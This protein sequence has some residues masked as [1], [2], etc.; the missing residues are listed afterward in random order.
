[1]GDPDRSEDVRVIDGTNLVDRRLRRRNPLSR[2]AGVVDQHV[3]PLGVLP[4]DAYSIGNR[5]VG[6]HVQGDHH[7]VRSTADEFVRGC[8]SSTFIT[9]AEKYLPTQFPE[10]A[11]RLKAKSLVASSDQNRGLFRVHDFLQ[12][13]QSKAR[14][15]AATTSLWGT[16]CTWWLMFQRC[17]KGSSS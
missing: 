5:L 2:G 6:G 10:P 7:R 15:A 8:P 9:R 16:S 12:A 3:Q 11:G 13:R 4:D 1:M 14:A 17:P